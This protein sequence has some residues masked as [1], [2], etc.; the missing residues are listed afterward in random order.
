MQQYLKHNDV[1]VKELPTHMSHVLQ[2][3]DVTVFGRF[4]SF[5]KR[6]VHNK[7]LGEPVLDNFG[8]TDIIRYALSDSL[9]SSNV[10]SGFKKCE[11]WDVLGRTESLEPLRRLPFYTNNGS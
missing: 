9:T 4:K 1:V 10:C 8:V 7:A 11:V 3:L 2:P 5:L 6:E